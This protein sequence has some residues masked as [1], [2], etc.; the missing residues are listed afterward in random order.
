M[1]A[2]AAAA[3][4]GYNRLRMTAVEASNPELKMLVQFWRPKPYG[5][6]AGNSL[7]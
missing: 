1:L 4:R 7:D 2:A 5:F 6:Q 3:A